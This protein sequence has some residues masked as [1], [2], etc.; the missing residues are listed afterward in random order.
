MYGKA[1]QQL[2]SELEQTA[3]VTVTI[4]GRDLTLPGILLAP[5]NARR[6]TLDGTTTLEI[7]AW[8]IAPAHGNV[9]ALDDIGNICEKLD[10]DEYEFTTLA[11]PSHSADALPA[12]LA[13]L[14][15][16]ITKETN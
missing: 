10:F 1:L 5:R 2:A 15:I 16:E 14:E 3:G 7:E 6:E 8:I 11:M 9:F 13:T 4:D 12:A